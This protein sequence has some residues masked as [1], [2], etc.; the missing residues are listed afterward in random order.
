MI[1]PYQG[2]DD[3]LTDEQRIKELKRLN[4][5]NELF[6]EIKHGSPKDN[7]LPKPDGMCK[8]VEMLKQQPKEDEDETLTIENLKRLGVYDEVV[9][10][11]KDNDDRLQPKGDSTIYPDSE[12]VKRK[13][14]LS[15]KEGQLNTLN[16]IWRAIDKIDNDINLE[17]S[18]HGIKCILNELSKEINGD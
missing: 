5:E 7:D 12:S 8:A 3:E 1:P 11:Y 4:K 9:S 18:M 13:E 15:Y 17:I 2:L 14:R 6:R 10:F 16:R